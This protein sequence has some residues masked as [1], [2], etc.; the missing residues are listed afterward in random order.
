MR[1]LSRFFDTNDRELSR[2]QPL[3]DR[4]NE[5]EPEFDALSDDELRER[6]EAIRAEIAED[7]APE[8]PSDD[9]CAAMT[10]RR[11]AGSATSSDCRRSSTT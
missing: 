11:R 10:S 6:M 1:F 5:L 8:E 2:I 9:S 3:I 4:T 7:A